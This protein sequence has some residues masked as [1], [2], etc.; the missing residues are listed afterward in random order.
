MLEHRP[1]VTAEWVS[2]WRGLGESLPDGARLAVDPFGLGCG[3]R[4]G[5]LLLRLPPARRRLA[6]RALLATRMRRIILWMQVRTRVI[7]D[8]L[9]DFVRSGGRQ[10][11]ILGA[12]FDCRAARFREALGSARVFEVDH[13][14]SQGSKLRLLRRAQCVT[15][16]ATF[17]AWDFERD[18]L[19][20]LP[21]TLAEH[22]HDPH[23]ATL[24]IWEGVVMYL[25]RDAIGAT[26]DAV[27]ELSGP[28]SLLVF[29]YTEPGRIAPWRAVARLVG[30]PVRSGLWPQHVKSLAEARGLTVAWDRDDLDLAHELLSH[31]WASRFPG[32]GGRIA[33]VRRGLV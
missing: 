7:D 17:I 30:E 9:L 32:A 29:N 19:G 25:S 33:L 31:T 28:G 20:H 6:A 2:T 16:N 14:A 18:S 26:L 5:A 12:G 27:V 3:S 8:V 24:T 15:D 1:S 21:K 4:M 10:V 23:A 22:G 11:V 13:P